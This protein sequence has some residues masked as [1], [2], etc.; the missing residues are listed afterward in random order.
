MEGTSGGLGMHSTRLDY[1]QLAIS[2][3]ICILGPIMYSTY[4][5]CFFILL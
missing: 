2:G 4:A 1:F 3:H 5:Y